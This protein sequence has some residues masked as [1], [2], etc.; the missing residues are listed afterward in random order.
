MRAAG[1]MPGIRAQIEREVAS[2]LKTQLLEEMYGI[3]R[4][5]KVGVPGADELDQQ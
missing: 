5:A 4:A 3:T 1:S 2:Q